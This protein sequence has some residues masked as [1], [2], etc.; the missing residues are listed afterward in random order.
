M[1]GRYKMQ[2]S[3]GAGVSQRQL[4][5]YMASRSAFR[6]SRCSTLLNCR[7]SRNAA[8]VLFMPSNDAWTKPCRTP[9]V[10][11]MFLAA[12]GFGDLPHDFRGSS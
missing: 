12:S 1:H 9:T 10:W 3:C 2:I 7:S 6:E 8:S 11:I 4:T 5:E